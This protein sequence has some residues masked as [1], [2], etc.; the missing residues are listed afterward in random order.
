MFRDTIDGLNNVFETDI[1]R[2]SVILVTGPPGSL[3]SG[4]SYNILSKYLENRDEFGM[5]MTLEETTES[6]LRNM[7]SLG[8][9]IP[10]NLLI[11][12]YSD[13]RKR[14]E[15]AKVEH[16]DFLQMIEGVI[17]FF[18]NK[19]GDN[20]SCFALDSLGALYSL[21]DTRVGLR[22]KM[23]HF[24]KML[25]SYNLISFIVMETPR[26]SNVPQG[27]GA[28]GFLADGIIEM[29]MIETQH[30]IMLYMQVQKMR[31]TA[32]SRKKHLIE[33]TPDGLVI[34]GPVFE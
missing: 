6:H 16:P 25:R 18:K 19:E 31:A 33:I 4:F 23:Y 5:Y 8:I 12:D 26:F 15:G 22:A 9:T 20:F 10:D 28:E 21:T 17:K 13:I 3:K 29:G 14:F 27:T 1:Y 32:H 30:D 24:F 2:G 7:Q 34:L 11:S